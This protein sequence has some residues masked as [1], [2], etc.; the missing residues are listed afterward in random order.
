MH[1]IAWAQKTLTFMSKSGECWQ[2]KHT[3]R[4]PSIKTECDYLYGWIKET[5]TYAKI[6]PKMTNPRDIAGE[7][8]RKSGQQ[9]YVDTRAEAIIVSRQKGRNSEQ[10]L[11]N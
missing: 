5:V 1:S 8:R 9:Y 2:Q 6:S 4:A 7:H 10:T 3:Q 11:R